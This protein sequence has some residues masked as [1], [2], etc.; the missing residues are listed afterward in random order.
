MSS[1]LLTILEPASAG[2]CFSDRETLDRLYEQHIAIAWFA[3]HH[4]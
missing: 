1:A 2:F 3:K 4:S